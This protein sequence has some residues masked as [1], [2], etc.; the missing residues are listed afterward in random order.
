MGGLVV[1]AAR[2]E[3]FDAIAALVNVYIRSTA[4]H[5]GYEEQTAEELL[6]MCHKGAARYPWVVAEV[7]G[8]FAGYAKAGVWRERAAYQWTPECGVYVEKRF[9]RL[10]VGRAL[11]A[12]LFEVMREQG[13]ESV[14]AGITL[15]NEASVRL[16]E[17]MGFA[18]AGVVRRAGWKLEKWWDV[19]FW[20]KE[21]GTGGRPGEIGLIQ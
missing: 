9:Q 4:I 3:D 12:R 18:P 11:Y 21:L 10:G 15:P 19:G 6:A 17:A 20:Q 5:F 8:A 1:R 2:A 7:D 16:H 14:I 13:F